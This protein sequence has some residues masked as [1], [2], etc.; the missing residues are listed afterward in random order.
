MLCSCSPVR[1][2]FG[3]SHASKRAASDTASSVRKL[4]QTMRVRS[5]VFVAYLF[6]FA[7][8]ILAWYLSCHVPKYVDPSTQ[9]EIDAG[10]MIEAAS[11]W[12]I[13]SPVW[14][15]RDPSEL[16]NSRIR[17]LWLLVSADLSR[18]ES[19][20]EIR[21]CICVVAALPSPEGSLLAPRRAS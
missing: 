5:K 15:N 1:I 11:S 4:I 14:V 13:T 18:A 19:G 12:Y 20:I 17:T 9:T 8:S 16:H 21:P 7:N 10:N 6:L 3:S 2:H